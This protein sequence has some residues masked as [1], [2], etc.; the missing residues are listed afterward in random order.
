MCTYQ[1]MENETH[2]RT[3]NGRSTWG[4]GAQSLTCHFWVFV[5][6][7]FGT[8]PTAKLV[9]LV[10]KYLLSTFYRLISDFRPRLKTD[11]LEVCGGASNMRLALLIR[12]PIPN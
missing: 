9:F 1:K 5:H 2:L 10:R 8:F 12:L 6:N 7:A 3:A 4:G 11:P